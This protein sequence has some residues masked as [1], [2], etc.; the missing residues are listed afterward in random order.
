[1]PI[2]KINDKEY[3]SDL[4]SKEAKDHLGSLQFVE[5]EIQR[6]QAQIAVLQTARLAYGTA[7]MQALSAVPAGDTIKLS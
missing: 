4:I 1:M 3:D 5:A 6:H 2:I 7:L